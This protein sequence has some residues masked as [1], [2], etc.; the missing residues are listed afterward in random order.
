MG[1][2]RGSARVSLGLV[3]GVAMLCLLAQMQPTLAALYTVGGPSGWTFN[4]QNWPRGKPFKAGDILAFNYAR[5][6]HN[7]VAVTS[8]GFNSCTAPKGSKVYQ[9][10]RDRIRLSRGVNYFICTFP[11]HCKGGMKIAVNAA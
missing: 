10:G 7:V 5:N 2:G 11:G 1:Q 8:R 9:T 6:A 3:V 4:V